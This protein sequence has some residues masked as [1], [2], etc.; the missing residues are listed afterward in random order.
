MQ[1]D[2][3]GGECI[4]T[5]KCEQNSILDASIPAG[6]DLGNV[7]SDTDRMRTASSGHRNRSAMNSAPA[8]DAK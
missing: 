7:L 5:R 8:A 3:E 1:K 6:K 2:K 4:N